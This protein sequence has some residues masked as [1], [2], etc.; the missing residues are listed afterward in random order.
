MENFNIEIIGYIAGFITS[1]SL[2]PQIY[3]L[4]KEQKADGVSAMYMFVLLSG[5]LLWLWYG[6][7]TSTSTIIVANTITAILIL[8]TIAQIKYI[9]G[10]TNER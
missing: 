4:Y 9:Q 6:L 3:K 8:I 10:K 1:F 5:V 2:V 7:L